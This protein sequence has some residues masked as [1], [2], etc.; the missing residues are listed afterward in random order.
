A[1]L[2][3]D[4]ADRP[5]PAKL[6]DLFVPGS[7]PYTP[8]VVVPAETPGAVGGRPV[9]DR[10]VSDRPHPAPPRKRVLPAVLVAAAV[11]AVLA[12]GGYLLAQKDDRGGDPSAA[13]P[14]PGRSSSAT[15]TPSAPATTP[16]TT[17][18]DLPDDV[19]VVVS[20][21]KRKAWLTVKASD[22][23]TLFDDILQRGQTRTF[24]D[25][26]LLNVTLGDADAF[27]LVV[28][29]EPVEETYEPGQVERLAFH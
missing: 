4:P 20:A 23:R 25:E 10:S 1:C 12:G 17:A 9:P 8:T 14:G 3:K 28:N 21:E 26:D 13:A 11:I 24:K 29:G 22:G 6:L 15:G 16:P 27:R 18:A 5:T 7:A 19:T 2:A